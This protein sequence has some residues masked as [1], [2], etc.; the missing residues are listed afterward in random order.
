MESE[1]A[2]HMLKASETSSKKWTKIRNYTT[3]KHCFD[4]V[5]KIQKSRRVLS[6]YSLPGCEHLITRSYFPRLID[7]ISSIFCSFSSISFLS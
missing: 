2:L 7:L 1:A 5:L 6:K 4:R 3:L